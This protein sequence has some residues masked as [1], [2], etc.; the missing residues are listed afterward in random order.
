MVLT[1]ADDGRGI[2]R[3]EI[4]GRE[5]LGLIGIRE[6]VLAAGGNVEIHGSPGRGTTTRISIPIS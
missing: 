2:T 6:R 5:S 3:E 1:V 4:D